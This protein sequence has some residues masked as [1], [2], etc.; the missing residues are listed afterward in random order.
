MLLLCMFRYFDRCGHPWAGLVLF[1]CLLV[2]LT[3]FQTQ[4]QTPTETQSLDICLGYEKSADE[5][6]GVYVGRD[7][8]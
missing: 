3:Q 5:G 8:D 1:D 2:A 7:K 6:N 4:T